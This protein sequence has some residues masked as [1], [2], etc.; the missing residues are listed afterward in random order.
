MY[1]MFPMYTSAWGKLVELPVAVS[2]RRTLTGDPLERAQ[3]I[4]WETLTGQS[5]QAYQC[6]TDGE[7]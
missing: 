4:D 2:R 5:E 6:A 1:T 7:W 3:Q